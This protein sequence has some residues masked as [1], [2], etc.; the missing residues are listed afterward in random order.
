MYS[1]VGD[2]DD[3]DETNTFQFGH[4]GGELEYAHIR[5]KRAA[6]CQYAVRCQGK[7]SHAKSTYRIR[8]HSLAIAVTAASVAL[9]I[10][11]EDGTT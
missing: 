8:I 10:S 1:F 2:V 6:C 7:D 11:F 4:V 3:L 9:M 5:Q